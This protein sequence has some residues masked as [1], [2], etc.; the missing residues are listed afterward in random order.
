[1]SQSGWEAAAERQQRRSCEAPPHTRGVG[2]AIQGR[3]GEGGGRTLLSGEGSSSRRGG[4]HAGHQEGETGSGGT[5]P[6]SFQ[7][8]HGH[9]PGLPGSGGDPSPTPGVRPPLPPPPPLPGA[10]PAPPPPPAA[11]G[12][13]AGALPLRAGL[14]AAV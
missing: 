7:P 3:K 11:R 4:H 12:A 8:A 14:P 6:G 10:A 1:M 9:H 2:S 5:R 13:G